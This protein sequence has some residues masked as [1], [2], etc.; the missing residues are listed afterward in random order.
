MS[1]EIEGSESADFG[2]GI[3]EQKPTFS[4]SPLISLRRFVDGF[5]TWIKADKEIR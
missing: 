1:S 5:W 2:M 4:V 3:A